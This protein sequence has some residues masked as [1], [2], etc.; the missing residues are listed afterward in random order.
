M[1]V[2]DGKKCD[3]TPD[4]ARILAAAILAQAGRDAAGGDDLARQWL[5]EAG[6]DLLDQL[7]AAVDLRGWLAELAPS[8][9][10]ALPGM[11]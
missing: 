8:I 1:M 4:G 5:A 11:G 2:N 10:P 9:Q 6:D 3:L 7:G